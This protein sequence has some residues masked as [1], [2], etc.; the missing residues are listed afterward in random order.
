MKKIKNSNPTTNVMLVCVLAESFA[1][2]LP[3][4]NITKKIMAIIITPITLERTALPNKS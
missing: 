4:L 2:E 3:K 1:S